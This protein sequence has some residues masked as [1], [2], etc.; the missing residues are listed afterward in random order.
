MGRRTFLIIYYL[1]QLISKPDTPARIQNTD[2]D[3]FMVMYY[4]S[5]VYQLKALVAIVESMGVIMKKPEEE[6]AG[7]GPAWAV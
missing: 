5:I 1:R 7:E 4:T 2:N 6:R 3:V